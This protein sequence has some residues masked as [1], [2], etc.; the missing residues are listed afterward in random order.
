M[1]VLFF[2]LFLEAAGGIRE[3]GKAIQGEKK[4]RGLQ[5]TSGHCVRNNV[6]A[7][8]NNGITSIGITVR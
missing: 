5:K 4:D 3:R 8:G 6:Q 7:T 2:F 1:P